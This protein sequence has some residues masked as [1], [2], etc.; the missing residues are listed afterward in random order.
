V[1]HTRCP[2]KLGAICEEKVP[3]VTA[4]NSRHTVRCH[5]PADQLPRQRGHNQPAERP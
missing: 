4:L 1:F 5:I 3:D 2:H